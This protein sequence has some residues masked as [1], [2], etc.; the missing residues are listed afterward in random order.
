MA[1]RGAGRWDVLVQARQPDEN[2]EA[3]RDAAVHPIV[4]HPD[5]PDTFGPVEEE[6][7]QDAVHR[8][9][10]LMPMLEFPL[11]PL[12]QVAATQEHPA[13]RVPQAEVELL[14]AEQMAQLQVLPGPQEQRLQE[15]LR[16]WQQEVLEQAVEKVHDQVNERLLLKAPVLVRKAW[17]D[18]SPGF[19]ESQW[20]PPA[21]LLEEAQRFPGPLKALPLMAQASPRP[22]DDR[23]VS[24]PQSPLLASPLRP[25]L[26]SPPALRNAFAQAP[27]ARDRA[28]SS[29]SFF[30]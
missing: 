30:Q 13:D 18:A 10:F 28:N 25:Q 6:H 27:R 12:R 29:A 21:S 1:Y 16:V 7:P 14:D 23:T 5:E 9:W 8:N 3:R 17:Q 26:P 22:Q 4:A 24:S 11:G 19:P 2:S 15:L 20:T